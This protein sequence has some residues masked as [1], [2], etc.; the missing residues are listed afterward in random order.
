MSPIHR[1]ISL[2]LAVGALAVV[3]PARAGTLAPPLARLANAWTHSQRHVLAQASQV[4]AGAGAARVTAD[5]RVEVYVR[6]APGVTPDGSALAALGARRILTVP[7]LGTI[8]AWLPIPDLARAAVLP[9]V[10]RVTLPSYGYVKKNALASVLHRGIP[11]AELPQGLQ[12]DKEGIAGMQVQPLLNA[13]I[14]GYGV[15][16]GV[17]SDGVAGLSASQQAGYL[18]GNIFVDTNTQQSGAE[19]T[20]MLEEVHAM[21]PGAQLGFC[22]GG[23]TVDFVTCINDLYNSFNADVIVDDLGYFT[24]FIYNQSDG[25][26]FMNAVSQFIANHPDTNLVTAA[27]NDAQ[28]YFQADYI[29]DTNPNIIS[30][31][32]NYTPGPGQVGGRTYQSAMNFGAAAGG[33]DNATDAVSIA[34]GLLYPGLALNAILTWNDPSGGPYDDLDLFL[35]KSDGTVVASSTYDQ[36]QGPNPDLGDGEYIYYENTTNATQ[37]LYLAALCFS[38]NNPI[39]V[40][41]TGFLN[42]GG[43][44]QLNTQGS[45]NGHS[46]LSGEF[47][48]GAASLASA[49][50]TSVTATME[51][52]SDSGPYTYGDWQSGTQTTPKPELVGIDGVTVSGAGGFPTPF[53]GTSAAAPNAASEIALLRSGF[54]GSE[55]DAVGW[56]GVVETNADTGALNL[57]DPNV[58]GFGLGDARA[59]AIALD[60]GPIGAQITSPPSSPI[61]VAPNTGVDFAGNCS[62]A[63]VFALSHVWYFGGNSGIPNSDKLTPNPVQ[64]ANGGVYDVK[65]TC[66]DKL[67]SAAAPFVVKVNAAA[68]AHNLSLSLQENHALTGLVAASHVGGDEVK[69]QTVTKPTY[70]TVMLDSSNGVFTYTPGKNFVGKDSFQF[71]IDNGVQVSNVATV[72]LNVQSTPASGGGSG[73]GWFELAAL[74]ALATLVRRLR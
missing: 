4:P 31:D 29:A 56:A 60:G 68:V 8:E 20:A 62:Y 26:S 54:S 71:D 1:S 10:A 6:Y 64:Y 35:V 13:G 5:G 32:P 15:R 21:A 30:L 63:G 11:S 39:L 34:S 7:A 49:S 45:I 16:I 25:D 44:F 65:F 53:Y 47:T 17:I 72:T 40:K 46:G 50:G 48:V 74:A 19:G 24:A 36:T 51:N 42:G 73:F 3:L 33:G 28:D 57:S 22:A 38:C 55:P 66:S 14:K 37:T 70:G 43:T 58:I 2:A 9:G 52:F 41:L 23:S 27:G 61:E 69:Y 67:Q 12:I 18:P 59:A